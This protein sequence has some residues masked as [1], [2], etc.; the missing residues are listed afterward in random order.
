MNEAP[1]GVTPIRA[2]KFAKIITA[3]TANI[4]LPYNFQIRFFNEFIKIGLQQVTP[5]IK[6]IV[7]MV[8]TVL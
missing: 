5:A 8:F 6:F 2:D 4:L 1:T 3:V 7:F